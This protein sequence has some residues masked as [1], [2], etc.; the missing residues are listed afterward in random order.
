MIFYLGV[1]ESAWLQWA[2]VPLC[3]SHR[4]LKRR[5]T[6][7]RAIVP[8]VLDSGGFSEL[9]M[10]GTWRTT[11]AEYLAAVERYREEVGLMEWAAVQDWMCE[12][13]VRAQTGGTVALHQERTVMS[14]LQLLERAP[15]VTW[16]PVLQGWDPW[17]YEAHW[18][19]YD[20]YGIDLE[21]LSCVGLG[22]VCRRQS[23]RIIQGIVQRLQPLRLHGFGVKVAGLKLIG[24]QLVSAD[25]MAWSLGARRQPPM[26]GCAHRS[27]QNCLR[28]A[29]WWAQ[30]IQGAAD[31][32]EATTQ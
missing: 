24:H 2:T 1:H 17:E 25:S 21:N 32:T 26:A 27:C 28:Y 23:D 3:V 10:Y 7:P 22:S 29:E 8:W 12:P 19:L 13:A 11:P 16:L 20:R 30:R 6:M 5:V 9:T 4:R 31:G 15:A 18:S 14:Y